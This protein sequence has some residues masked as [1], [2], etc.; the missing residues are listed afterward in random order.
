MDMEHWGDRRSKIEERGSW[1]WIMDMDMA[2]SKIKEEKEAWG[3]EGR[4]ADSSLPTI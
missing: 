2:G 4:R 1:T 3:I